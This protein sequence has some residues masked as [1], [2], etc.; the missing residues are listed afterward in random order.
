MGVSVTAGRTFAMHVLCPTDFSESAQRAAEVAALLAARMKMPL[1]LQHSAPDA[2][3]SVEMPVISQIEER[4]KAA[5]EEEA[6]RLRA[7]GAEVETDLHFGRAVDDVVHGT[8]RENT[9][10]VVLGSAGRGLAG[11]WLTGNVA[12]RVAEAVPVPTLVV[13]QPAPLM[14]WLQEGTP[15]KVL[16]GVDFSITADAALL[17]VK[18]LAKVAPCEV[19]AA[20]IEWPHDWP[21]QGGEEGNPEG[22]A[23]WKETME[24]HQ[25]D[26][27][28]RVG[29]LLDGVPVR[30]HV[31]GTGG[32]L[33][34]EF[35]RLAEEMASG[36]LVVGAHQW[37]GLQRLRGPS[38]SRGVLGQAARNV[39]C[40]PLAS[41]T[42]EFSVSPVRSVLVATDFSANG[43][44]ALR[45]AY[46][47]LE[48][49][50][51]IHLFHVAPLGKGD[52]AILENGSSHSE[53]EEARL[54]ALVPKELASRRVKVG[55]KAVHR[56]DVA[57]AICEEA[58][59]RRVD[60]ICMGT[61]GHTGVVAA[62]LGSVAQAV[63]AHSRIP[64]LAVPAVER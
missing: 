48:N 49:G 15:L 56:H 18:S 40:V 36:L 51:S 28:E 25:R 22:D 62:V 23:E 43:N 42:P 13:R 46:G 63:L 64:V 47:V 7:Y 20:F 30:A 31:R 38:F 11:R 12:E 26:L 21:W 52:V 55:L 9:R 17:A 27:W 45:V 33:D 54:L 1:K 4:A 29:G 19:D 41:Y 8:H 2:V 34:Y 5:L 44:A 50:G 6:A 3:V 59:R 53:A 61:R 35:V 24:S 16:C 10:M 39:L 14:K 57:A 58:E 32:R 37:H 60:L